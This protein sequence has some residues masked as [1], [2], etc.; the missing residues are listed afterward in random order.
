MSLINLI[1]MVLLNQLS[2]RSQKLIKKI[3]ESYL[4]NNSL[5]SDNYE[6]ISQLKLFYNNYFNTK[7]DNKLIA[8]LNQ[9]S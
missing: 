3:N 1:E 6:N 4:N 5:Y 8:I 9:L 7:K 2:K